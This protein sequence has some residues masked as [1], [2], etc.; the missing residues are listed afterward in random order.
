MRLIG[1]DPGLATTGYAILDMGNRRHTL[2]SCGVIRT[3]AHT[4]LGARLDEIQ[5]DMHMLLKEFKPDAAAIEELFFSKN[6]STGIQVAHARGVLI[7]ALH[8]NNIPI[9]EFTPSEMKKALTGDGTADK[10][11]IQKMV[12]M[13]LQ[14]KQMPKPDDAADAISLALTLA[15]NP[16][17]KQQDSAMLKNKTPQTVSPQKQR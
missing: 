9:T 15:R 8:A 7:W 3:P 16:L 2:V 14:L 6:V 13:E 4:P 12:L 1:I 11:A 17:Q 10:W 5:A